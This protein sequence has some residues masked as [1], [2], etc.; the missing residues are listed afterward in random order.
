MFVHCYIITVP[1]RAETSGVSARVGF[2]RRVKGSRLGAAL[3][4]SFEFCQFKSKYIVYMSH[5]SFS[6]I[7]LIGAKSKRKHDVAFPPPLI[8]SPSVHLWLPLHFSAPHLFLCPSFLIGCTG[9]SGSLRHAV[10]DW[11]CVCLHTWGVCLCVCVWVPP[12]LAGCCSCLTNDTGAVV[13]AISPAP[14]SLPNS[15]LPPPLLYPS[16]TLS[17]PHSLIPISSLLIN[18]LLFTDMCLKFNPHFV[19]E[20]H[21][22][23]NVLLM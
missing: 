6:F 3:Y 11:A 22:T 20:C 19:S 1:L 21:W 10:L 14:Y 13:L 5:E 16:I 9:L 15:R 4:D 8:P 18:A 7:A 2:E 12:L 23:V 17:S